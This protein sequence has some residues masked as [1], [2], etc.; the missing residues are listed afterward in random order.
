MKTDEIKELFMQENL[1][2][3]LKMCP[4]TKI[5][6]KQFGYYENL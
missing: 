2:K 1:R 3:M 4:T 5:C 6:S